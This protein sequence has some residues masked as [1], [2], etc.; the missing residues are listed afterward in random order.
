MKNCCSAFSKSNVQVAHE[1]LPL[2]VFQRITQKEIAMIL[3]ENEIFV[4]EDPESILPEEIIYFNVQN[5]CTNRL[6]RKFTGEN[7]WDS[8]CKRQ[9]LHPGITRE[10]TVKQDSTQWGSNSIGEFILSKNGQ[11]KL[12]QKSSTRI[13]SVGELER[14]R[15]LCLS[16]HSI[17]KD[18]MCY[19][20]RHNQGVRTQWH[21]QIQL[22]VHDA[23]VNECHV[24]AV[25]NDRWNIL[26]I[27]RC[28]SKKKILGQSW[29]NGR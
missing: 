20:K 13:S 14:R 22:C 2:A 21:Q 27:I 17:W 10:K 26:E 6:G 28:H 5:K 8:L 7:Q 12:N 3:A 29:K 19:L 24:Y 23:S 15:I 1:E 25:K 9:Q 16:W 11:G 18:Q 4:K